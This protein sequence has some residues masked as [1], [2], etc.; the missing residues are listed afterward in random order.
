M[1]QGIVA[2]I[3]WASEVHV[4]CVLD[5]DGAVTGRFSFTHDGAIRSMVGRLRAAGVAGVAIERGDGPVVEGL[6]GAGL[7]DLLPWRERTT[8]PREGSMKSPLHEGQRPSRVYV[9]AGQLVR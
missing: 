4:A 7:A 3:Y 8:Q 1:T 2:G 5:A 6:L 9:P